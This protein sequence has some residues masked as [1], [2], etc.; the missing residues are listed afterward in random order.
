MAAEPKIASRRRFWRIALFVLVVLPLLPEI[1]VLSVSAIADLSGCRV[2]AAPPITAIDGADGPNADSE[3][4]PDPWMFTKGSV[5]KAC[6]I[7]PLPPISNIIRL[8]LEAGFFVG[9]SFGYGV[10][11]I[12]LALC[13]ISISRG[14]ARFLSRLTLAFIVSLIFAFLPYFGPTMSILHLINPYC[15]PN[16]GGVGSCVMYGGDV[17][18]IVHDNFVLGLHIFV[19]ARNALG[20]FA[21]YLLFLVI[22]SFVLRKGAVRSF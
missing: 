2:D 19:G 12:W 22:T 17:G 20:A 13:Y 9:D 4:P 16:E 5:P 11:I 18:S 21:V 1:V 15:Q 3:V 14:W 10:V 7:G 8:A 6:A